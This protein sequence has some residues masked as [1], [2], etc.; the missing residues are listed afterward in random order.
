MTFAKGF[1]RFSW[2]EKFKKE[3]FEDVKKILG[4]VSLYVGLIM[5]TAW[6]GW[7]S[8]IKNILCSFTIN[9]C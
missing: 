2:W 1:K 6:G 8:S 9:A 3:K 5:Y 4:H 7:V